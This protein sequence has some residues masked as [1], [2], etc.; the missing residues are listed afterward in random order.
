MENYMFK[1]QV[2]A[3]F[4]FAENFSPEAIFR[5]NSVVMKFNRNATIYQ[6]GDEA[7]HIYLIEEGDVRVSRFS[8]DGRELTLDHLSTGEVLGETE[9]LLNTPRESQATARGSVK[10]HAM[11]RSQMMT[12]AENNPRLGVWLMQLLGARQS[13][14]EN[15]ME[16]L[17]FKSANGKVA[18]VLLELAGQYGSPDK[19]GTR[20]EYP[21]THQEIGNLIATTRE[22]VSYVFMDLRDQGL[23]STRQR[24]TIVRDLVGLEAVSCC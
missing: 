1:H 16:S 21:I 19:E 4:P 13:R 11:E 6:P 2:E 23:I 15:K 8:S 17:L 3:V 12:L 14:M 20:I 5:E 9:L 22:T 7:T 10:L 24:K 18:Q